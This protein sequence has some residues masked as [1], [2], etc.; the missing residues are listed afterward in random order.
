MCDAP[1][2]FL[3]KKRLAN[4]PSSWVPVGKILLRGLAD[5]FVTLSLVGDTPGL[6]RD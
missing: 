3:G 5:T 6:R 4:L 2:T 1:L